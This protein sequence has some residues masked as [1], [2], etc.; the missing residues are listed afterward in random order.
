MDAVVRAL[1]IYVGLLLLFR[2]TGKRSMA[3]MT[4]FDFVLL[5]VVGE[6]TQQALLGEDFSFTMAII[7]IATLV[8]LDRFADYLG[9]RF[10]RADKLL[11]S[12]P[13]LL[14]DDGKPLPDRMKRAHLGEDDI[15]ASARQSQ[16]LESMAQ[17][18]YAVLEKDGGISIIPK[19]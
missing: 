19:G 14:V 7:V 2:I 9:F 4:T 8:G 16:G 5:L 17:I 15:L 1:V 6:A 13:V 18:K 12:V 11:E 10:P 3:S